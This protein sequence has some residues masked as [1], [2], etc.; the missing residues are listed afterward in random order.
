[1]LVAKRILRDPNLSK[2]ATLKFHENVDKLNDDLMCVK[3]AVVTDIIKV[4][5]DGDKKFEVELPNKNNN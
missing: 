4:K 2:L 1:M 5:N 3:G